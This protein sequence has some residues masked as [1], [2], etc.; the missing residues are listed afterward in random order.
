MNPERFE[1]RLMQELKN[2]VAQ[3]AQAASA[4]EKGGERTGGPAPVRGRRW[5]PVGLTAGLAASIAAAVLVLDPASGVG[6]TVAGG[7]EA[8]PPAADTIST[9]AYTLKRE[10]HGTVDVTIRDADAARPN[11]VRLQHDLRKMGVNAHVYQDD[12]TC[13][14]DRGEDPELGYTTL[15]AIDFHHR[16]GAFTATIRPDR[17]P[18]G[19]HLEIVFPPMPADPAQTD[20]LTF[21]LRTGAAPDCRHTVVPDS[22]LPAPTATTAGEVI[23]DRS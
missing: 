2:H 16:D 10:P 5:V 18:A 15:E 20:D 6:P 23:P 1:E 22:E 21:G 12:P 7:A 17:F 19:T 4:M 13:R 3:R 9:V 14:P 11:P 8:R